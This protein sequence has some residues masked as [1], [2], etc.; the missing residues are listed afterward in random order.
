MIR[1]RLLGVQFALPLLALI[2]PLLAMRLGMRGA[3]GPLM[4]ALTLHELGHLVAARLAHVE[5]SEIR[6][7][8]FGGSARIENPYGLTS[9]QLAA[10]AVAG[11]LINLVCT[12]LIAALAQ[13]HIIASARASSW[14]QPHIVLMLFNLLPALPL[15]GGRLLY[16]LL[17]R[18]LG[19]VRSF[20]ICRL[21]GRLLAAALLVGTLWG[22]IQYGKWNLTLLLAAIFIIASE[23]DERAA[24]G[25][26]R[27]RRMDETLAADQNPCPARFYQLDASTSAHSA[28][29]LLRPRERDWFLLT[30]NGI[31]S[32]IID[33]RSIVRFLMDGGTP[34]TA[35]GSL[36]SYQLCPTPPKY[37]YSS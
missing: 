26:S 22:G 27:L 10:V 24:L 20:Y 33:G 23:R 9:G 1:F 21:L 34:D 14:I 8:P 35:I 16:A 30:V 11:P 36:G 13:W 31:P 28:L 18:P 12:I 2:M 32:G 25:I 15:D 19:E 7:M 37:S 6:L 4:L 29:K 5:I 3:I 17:Q